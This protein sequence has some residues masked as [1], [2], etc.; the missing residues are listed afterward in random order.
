MIRSLFH[1]K[2]LRVFA[3]AVLAGGI[4]STEVVGQAKKPAAKPATDEMVLE[5]MLQDFLP[6]ASKK[7]SAQAKS[8]GSKGAKASASSSSSNGKS[9][10]GVININGKEIRTKDPKEFAQLQKQMQAQMGQLPNIA[11]ANAGNSAFQGVISIN[12]KEVRT[13]D[14]KEF[15]KLQQEMQAQFGQFPGFPNG[16]NA[17]NSATAS[18][19]SGTI[20]NNGVV[21]E[22]TDPAAFEKAQKQLQL[23]KGL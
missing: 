2:A 3:V 16:L 22:F 17:A 1:S 5:Q 6:N 23:P 15:E 11:Q 12:G 13:A 14:P 7:Q 19:F 4:L 9:F 20:N 8:T 10:E 21:Q 18:S